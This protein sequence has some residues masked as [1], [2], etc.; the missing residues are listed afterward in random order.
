VN[1]QKQDFIT[2]ITGPSKRQ[3]LLKVTN[4]AELDALNQACKTFDDE[5][6]DCPHSITDRYWSNVVQNDITVCGNEKIRVKSSDK[7]EKSYKGDGSKVTEAIPFDLIE[8]WFE[9][10][11]L[12]EKGV[13]AQCNV[14]EYSIVVV[15]KDPY[16][17]LVGKCVKSNGPGADG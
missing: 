11:N 15:D 7:Y 16:V 13:S 14:D 10:G 6:K 9:I 8:S 17:M 12:N 3:Y 2:E 4:K 1:V 5:G